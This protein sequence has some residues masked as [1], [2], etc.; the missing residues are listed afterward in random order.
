[1]LKFTHRVNFNLI[2]RALRKKKEFGKD[3][4]MEWAK[5]NKLI[6]YQTGTKIKIW[7]I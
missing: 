2:F 5:H 1:M 6:N 7:N 4:F 3:S